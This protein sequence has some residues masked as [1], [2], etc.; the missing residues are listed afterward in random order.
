MDSK[1][2][3]NLTVAVIILAFAGCS[4][5]G[6]GG[7]DALSDVPGTPD[8][9]VSDAPLD[10]LF[11]ASGDDIGDSPDAGDVSDQEVAQGDIGPD[12]DEDVPCIEGEPGCHGTVLIICD[13]N[14]GRPVTDCADEGWICRR[15]RCVATEE[16]DLTRAAWR[17]R[18]VD[19]RLANAG[20]V[21]ELD[22]F[23]GWKNAPE[24]LGEPSPGPFFRVEK[25]GGSW[26][27]ITPD[28][29]PFV[30]KGVT[31]LNWLG[32]HLGYDQYRELLMDKFGTEDV[33]ADDARDRMLGWNFNT[34]GPWSSHSLGTRMPHAFIILDSAGHAS[35]YDAKSLIPDFWSQ[36]FAENAENVVLARAA[37]FVED[38]NLIGYFLDNELPWVPNW[39]TS[40]TFL[41][42]NLEFPAHAPGRAEALA[43]VRESA[44][45]LDD[46]NVTWKTSLASWDD[47]ETISWAAFAP[48]TEAAAAVTEAFQLK[49]FRQYATVAIDALRK[50][51]QNHLILGCRFFSYHNDALV[52]E[53]AKFFDVI[54]LAFY[55]HV[56]PVEEIDGI[57]PQ[58]DKPFI[59]EE[60]SFKADDSGLMNILNYAPVVPTQKDR[61]LAYDEWVGTFMRRPYA[62]GYHWYKWVDNPTKEDNILAGDNFGLMNIMDE[63]YVPFVTLVRE[64]NFRIEKWHYDGTP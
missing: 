45:D 36:E 16:E 18:L 52:R 9:Q 40:K 54:S 37:P 58:I 43:F 38:E 44:A 1:V 32:E 48:V 61:G 49:A 2:K 64:V 53:A 34:I 33:W 20:T 55:W 50:V 24:A 12:T 7:E 6:G 11:D 47:L 57:Y 46:F 30:S 4:G 31:D 27:F 19:L 59:I 5:G 63:P 29:H 35:R 23:G 26:W 60:F 17:E 8:T 13:G 51:D 22:R 62:V 21:M 10:V 14:G 15:G 28:G 42:L 41:Q 39:S 25:R 56:P 3:K